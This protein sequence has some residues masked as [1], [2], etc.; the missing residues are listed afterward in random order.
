MRTP[1]GKLMELVSSLTDEDKAL[2]LGELGRRWDEEPRRIADAIDAMKVVRGELSYISVD[3]P[4]EPEPEPCRG[5]RWIGQS[6]ATCDGCGKPAWE[7][8][9]MLML[10]PGSSPFGDS[11]MDWEVKPW[12]PGEAD[13]IRRKWGRS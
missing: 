4:A 8:D 3:V 6:F 7:H 11:D 5:F 10:R 12:G 13:A 2:T 9:G 1:F